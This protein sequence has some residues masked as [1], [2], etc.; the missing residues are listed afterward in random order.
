M[1]MSAGGL[2][3][4]LIDAG[5]S[6]PLWA[7]SFPGKV[8]PGWMRKLSYLTWLLLDFLGCLFPVR[9]DAVWNSQE[10]CLWVLAPAALS[11]RLWPGR[12]SQ[13]K[14]TPSLHCLWSGIWSQQWRGYWSSCR[15]LAKDLSSI[16]GLVPCVHGWGFSQPW[17]E[18]T[19]KKKLSCVCNTYTW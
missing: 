16:P 1:G 11:G 7:A 19:L 5:R 10:A 2:S 8:A 6:T 18:N 17:I 12:V 13:I 4:L 9:V 15:L 14:S 3:S